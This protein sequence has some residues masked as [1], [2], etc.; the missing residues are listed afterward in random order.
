MRGAEQRGNREIPGLS[1]ARDAPGNPDV[2]RAATSGWR[3]EGNGWETEEGSTSGVGTSRIGRP[4][5]EEEARLLKFRRDRRELRD[6][7]ADHIADRVVPQ[8]PI[9][10]AATGEGV[11]TPT[12]KYLSHTC[13]MHNGIRRRRWRATRK[14]EDGTLGIDATTE[15]G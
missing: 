11:I 9:S 2:G 3:R 7:G 4:R 13:Y 14:S 6:R 10:T 15:K 8:N 1:E 5:G 12:V